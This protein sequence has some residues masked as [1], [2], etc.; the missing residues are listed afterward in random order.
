MKKKT[1]KKKKKGRG[2]LA[3]AEEAG[4][5]AAAEEV[6]HTH[7]PTHTHTHTHTRTG[8]ARYR[9]WP[10]AFMP[11]SCYRWTAACLR[12]LR[13]PARSPAVSGI[14]VAV[15][16]TEA[17]D[18]RAARTV[19]GSA[20]HLDEDVDFASMTTEELSAHVEAALALTR[21]TS[22]S[23]MDSFSPHVGSLDSHLAIAVRDMF[24]AGLRRLR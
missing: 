16:P 18:N 4:D 1:K 11:W 15:A 8:C 14:T 2:S 23:R 19:P 17:G 10:N 3:D 7:T 6:G 9:G 13:K 22:S 12:M 24:R 21:S 5:A 20:G